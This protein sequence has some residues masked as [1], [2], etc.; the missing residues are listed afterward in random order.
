MKITA[1]LLLLAA[2]L[3]ASAT[4]ARGDVAEWRRQER[5]CIKRCPQRKTFSGIESG[6]AW[7]DRVKA[8][9][10][11]DICYRKCNRQYYDHFDSSNFWPS[12]K[13]Q[14]YYDINKGRIYKR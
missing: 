5:E 11:N 14:L 3:A 10:A 8:D 1:F 4:P 7:R 12:S 6:Q 13:T 2:L 9:I